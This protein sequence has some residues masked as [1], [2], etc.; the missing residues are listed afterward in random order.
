MDRLQK[1]EQA[2]R[3]L[4]NQKNDNRAEM[5][6]WLVDNHVFVVADYASE[7]AKK[8]GANVELARVAALLHDIADAKMNR[9]D[10]AHAEESLRMAREFMKDFGYDEK[11]IQLVVEDAIRFHSCHDGQRPESL[12]GRV[13]ATADSLAHLKTDFYVFATW[14]LGR[15][16]T[17]IE[18]KDWVIQKIDRDLNNKILFDDEREDALLDYN[19]IKDLFSR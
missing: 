9:K 7:L 17:L 4:Y 14:A 2:V 5:A 11:E 18:I 1:L 16:M 10:T 6:D 3:D 13:L 12:E 15:E 8:Y 19:L